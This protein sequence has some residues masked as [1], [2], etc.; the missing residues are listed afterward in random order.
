MDLYGKKFLSI[1][2][3][4]ILVLIGMLVIKW[5]YV[6]LMDLEPGT[7]CGR[8]SVFT[9]GSTCGWLYGFLIVAVGI[10]EIFG[11]D[12]IQSKYLGD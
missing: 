1:G 12:Y 6:T 5:G 7:S 8:R 4:L 11:L 2:L 10:A 3:A 9:L